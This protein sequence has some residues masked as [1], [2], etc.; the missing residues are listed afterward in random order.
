M[1][2]ANP[3]AP[4]LASTQGCER[5]LMQYPEGGWVDQN[6]FSFFRMAAVAS[7]H[8]KVQASPACG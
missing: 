8:E 1:N 4:L 5:F 6:L 7:I 2:E 3:T